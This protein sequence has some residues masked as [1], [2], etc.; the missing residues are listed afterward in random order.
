M[1][2]VASLPGGGLAWPSPGVFGLCGWVNGE[3]QEGLHQGA[4]SSAPVLWWATA[5][6]TSIGG[7]PTLAGSFGSVS[8]GVTAL[9]L[10]VL[11]QAIFCC[12]LQDW[13]LCFSQ[14]SWSPVIKT[15]WPLQQISW[16]FPV[17]L[18]DPQ[19]GTPNVGFRTLT[20]MRELLWYYCSQVYGSPTQRV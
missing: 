11:V 13:N 7:P 17:P 4:P 3:L 20:P 6:Y 19:A 5:D 8:C 2:V 10:W 12:A 9:F 14:S 18:S 16:G 1:G 15:H